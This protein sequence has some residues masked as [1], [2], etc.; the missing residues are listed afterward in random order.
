MSQMRQAR[1]EMPAYV[2]E[3]EASQM[4]QVGLSSD[5]IPIANMIT[6]LALLELSR[7]TASGIESLEEDL[8]ADYYLWANRRER[9]YSQWPKMEYNF[10]KQTILRW[11]GARIR[12]DENCLVCGIKKSNNDNIFAE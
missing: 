8:I 6:K 9:V 3:I 1:S 5:I 12:R 2:S 4:I 10:N 7:G 11:Y